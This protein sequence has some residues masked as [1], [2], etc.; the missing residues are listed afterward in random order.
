MFPHWPLTH[1]LTLHGLVTSV[2][3]LFYVVS[4]HV[5]RHRRHPAAAIGWILFML[6][7]P[8]VALPSFM[9]FGS[10]KLTRPSHSPGPDLSRLCGTDAWAI[11]TIEALGQPAPAAYRD[12]NVHEDG[13][14]AC[15]ALF[16]MIDSATASIDLCTFILGCDKVGQAV[17]DRLC[18]KARS[19]VRVRLLLDGIGSLMERPP[20]L[21]KLKAA[22]GE[23]VLFV[24]PWHSPLKGRSNLRNHRKLV[25][26]DA[27]LNTAHLWCGGRNLAA[28]YFEGAHGKTPWRDLSF[29]L[30]GPLVSQAHDLFEQDWVFARRQR[31][32][33]Q[34][35]RPPI[36]PQ[37]PADMQAPGAHDG[38]QLMASGPDQT[39]DTVYALLVTAAYRARQRIA[40]STPYFVPDTALLMALCMAARRGVIVDLLVPAR[41]NH[42]LSDVARNRALRSLAAAGGRIWLMPG[43][44]HA[45]LAVIDQTLALVG[46]ANLDSRSLFLNYELMVA[47]H[48][49]SD[50]QR[51]T[52]WFDQ[53]QTAARPY[54][55][56]QP[57]LVRDIGEGMLLW[58][59]FQL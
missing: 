43:M 9:A 20:N 55:A 50:V 12:L 4:S 23:Y 38:A 26:A 7:L 15:H 22:G 39:D 57:G 3:V 36:P 42:G 33:K 18:L 25:I 28:A 35:E 24:P 2:A 21:R 31:P 48:K 40:L 37:T 58:L 27:A 5:M 14:Q 59:G 8:Y 30:K 17:V 44:L 54:V 16:D 45:K 6:L 41:S 51:F 32:V 1:W 56:H 34:Q 46:S 49:G 53:E 13:S 29:D 52:A 19:G 47:F 10:R 11:G